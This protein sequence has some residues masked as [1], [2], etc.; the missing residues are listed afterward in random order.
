M[1]TVQQLFHWAAIQREFPK[2]HNRLSH[3]LL[4]GALLLFHL[5]H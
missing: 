2:V 3:I 1:L 5:L 4:P